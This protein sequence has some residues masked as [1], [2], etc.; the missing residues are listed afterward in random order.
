MRRMPFALADK[1]TSGT[2]RFPCDND[3]RER[4]ANKAPAVIYSLF[5]IPYSLIPTP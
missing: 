1:P 3:T 5:P 2:L 4:V